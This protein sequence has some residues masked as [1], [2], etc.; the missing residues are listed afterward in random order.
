MTN[1]ILYMTY[2][3]DEETN[4]DHHSP[5]SLLLSLLWAVGCQAFGI[6]LNHLEIDEG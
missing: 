2:V 6:R 1:V 4:D 3:I 5:F